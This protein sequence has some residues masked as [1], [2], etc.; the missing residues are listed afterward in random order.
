MPPSTCRGWR[1]DSEYIHSV[2]VTAS[3]MS[4]SMNKTFRGVNSKT[5]IQHDRSCSANKHGGLA[6]PGKKKQ[7]AVQGR[8]LYG[9]PNVLLTDHG[10]PIQP[11]Q[12]LC[13]SY[14]C[15]PT[16]LK[17]NPLSCSFSSSRLQ[18]ILLLLFVFPN[19]ATRQIEPSTTQGSR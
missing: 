1:R 16:P 10:N 3:Q 19:F 11:L 9:V 6:E 7:R 5:S 14:V 12:L 15:R 2:H 18:S 17:Q 8:V 4:A 13:R